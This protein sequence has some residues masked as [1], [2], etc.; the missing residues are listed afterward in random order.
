MNKV[1]EDKNK[2]KPKN[3]KRNRGFKRPLGLKLAKHSEIIVK[4][5]KEIPDV[6]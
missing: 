5:L 4:D 2:L 1:I 3:A 6:P